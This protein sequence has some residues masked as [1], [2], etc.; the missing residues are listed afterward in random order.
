MSDPFRP[1]E[2]SPS[3]LICPWDFSGKNSG[4][5]CCS[6]LQGIFPT[7]GMNTGLL[8]CRQILYHLSYQGRPATVNGGLKIRANAWPKAAIGDSPLLFMPVCHPTLI[9]SCV[10]TLG[11]LFL[12]ILLS[13]PT[14][15][16]QCPFPWGLILIRKMLLLPA[17]ETTSL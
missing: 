5:G 14:W 6:L 13:E 17:L 7:Q 15:T 10:F 2:L 1:H 4:V 3:H 9:W 8:H 12:E 16:P 11:I